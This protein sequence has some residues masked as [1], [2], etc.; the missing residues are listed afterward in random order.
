[1]GGLCRDSPADTYTPS[2][3][4]T[5]AAAWTGLA[6]LW[7]GLAAGLLVWKR[8]E[9]KGPCLDVREVG[10]EGRGLLAALWVFLRLFGMG[11]GTLWGGVPGEV[12][13]GRGGRGGDGMR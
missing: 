10:V 4:P 8:G 9:A 7:T 12:P 6:A 2:P 1:M 5:L 13:E 3:V 11:G